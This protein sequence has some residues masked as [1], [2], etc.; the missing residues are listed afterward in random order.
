MQYLSSWVQSCSGLFCVF[1][2]FIYFIHSTFLWT[3]I[4]SLAFSIYVLY[5]RKRAFF[6]QK[7]SNFEIS[8]KPFTE[9]TLLKKWRVCS[10]QFCCWFCLFLYRNLFCAKILLFIGYIYHV[11]SRRHTRTHISIHFNMFTVQFTYP[12]LWFKYLASELFFY[13]WGTPT[14]VKHKW[15]HIY[16]IIDYISNAGVCKNCGRLP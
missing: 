9:I 4:V 5:N 7:T 13:E 12:K 8:Q 10:L 1:F 14:Q 6:T 11:N 3:H 15:C 2:F 16:R